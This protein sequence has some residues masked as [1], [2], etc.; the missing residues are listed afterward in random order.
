M[1]P[2]QTIT[3]MKYRFIL[4]AFSFLLFGSCQ[5]FFE[6][7]FWK[8]NGNAGREDPSSFAEIASIDVGD[9]GAAE[10]TAYDPETKRLLW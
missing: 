6:K 8:D 4:F 2:P 1:L 5:K 10:I 7:G 9:A 3:N